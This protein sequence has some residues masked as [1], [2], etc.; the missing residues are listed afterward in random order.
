MVH[1]QEDTKRIKAIRTE[2]PPSIDG[3]LNDSIWKRLPKASNFIQYRP[4][5]GRKSNDS[6]IAMITY[7]DDAIYVAAYLYDDPE[8]IQKV[9]SKRDEWHTNA[10]KFGFWLSPFNDGVN[11]YEFWV[12]AANVQTDFKKTVYRSDRNWDEVWESETRIAEH[13]WIV[14]MRIP[15]AAIRFPKK[16]IQQWGLNF[17]R[18]NKRTG[19]ESSWNYIDSKIPGT[20]NQMG[21][22]HNI[23]NIKP[24]LRLTF[25]PYASTYIKN[26]DEGNNVFAY[27][28]GMDFRYGINESYTLDMMVIPDFGQVQSDDIVLNLSPYEVK[29]KERRQFFIEGSEMFDKGGIFY[30]KRIGGEPLNYDK[31]DDK[32]DSTAIIKKNPSNTQIINATKVSGRSDRGLGIG[33]LNAMTNNTFATIEDTIT[34]DKQTVLTQPFTNYNVMVADQSLKNNSYASL[35]NT[36]YYNYL[37]NANVTATDF[38]LKNKTNTIELRGIGAVSRTQDKGSDANT[39]YRYYLRVGKI[40]GNFRYNISRS[41][42]SNNYEI[43]DMGFLSRNNM[44]YNRINFYYKK[45]HMEGIILKN[46]FRYSLAYDELYKP[47]KFSKFR[48]N[49][50]AF[51]RLRDY[52]EWRLNGILMPVEDHDYFEPRVEGRVFKDRP[53][54]YLGTSY[55]TDERKKFVLSSRAAW[56]Q[57]FTQK[58]ANGYSFSVNPYIALTKKFSI[59]YDWDYN[60]NRNNWGFV[61]HTSNEDTI[62][63]GQRNI[64]TIEN[65]IS[66]TFSFS[67]DASLSLRMRHYWREVIYND[68]FVLNDDGYLNDTDYSENHDINFNIFNID[69]VYS[70]RFAPGSEMSIMWKNAINTE[71]EEEFYPN[72]FNNFGHTITSPQTNT[73]SIKILYYLDYLKLKKVFA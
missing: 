60:L 40:G 1:G 52:S 26:T 14:E 70:W 51:A 17:F 32:K 73:F 46:V 38:S 22:M 58:N 11:G 13:G 65:T 28:G 8:K 31:P 48:M 27:K 59:D 4:Y 29:Y 12:T 35:I 68:Y 43:N 20:L 53:Y 71:Q 37:R 18:M 24:P 23:K 72:Y 57:T 64:T 41:L 3:K 9:L 36:N 56:W 62:Y 16:E 45:T 10:D 30:S 19:E 69:M 61:D 50:S 44:V 63:F 54:Y 47:R 67:E 5:N 2:H 6:T 66:A 39:G 33:V 21:V 7:D 42:R 55:N 34:G 15:F 49:A 25:T